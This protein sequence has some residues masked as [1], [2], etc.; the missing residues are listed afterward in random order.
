MESE[1]HRW[2]S[3]RIGTEVRVRGL[4]PATRMDPLVA[5]RYE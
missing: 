3:D 1:T 4:W 5:L 2:Y